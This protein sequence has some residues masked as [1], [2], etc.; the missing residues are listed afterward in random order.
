M[1]SLMVVG[2]AVGLIG[3]QGGGEKKVTLETQNDKV[4]YS[5]GV[6]IGNSLKRDSIVVEPEIVLRGMK[7]ASLDSA[8]RLLTEAQVQEI[9]VAFRQEMEKKKMEQARAAGDKNKV[10]GEAFLAANKTR[11]GVVTLPSGLQYEV[12]TEGKGVRPKP[13]QAVTT[14]YRGTLIDG[15]EFDSSYK[16]GEPAVFPVNRVIPGWTEALQLMKV[17][18]KWKLYVP[19]ALAYGERSPGGQIGP[20]QTLMFEIELLSIHG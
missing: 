14:H 2:I 7:D 15:T 10:E 20:N 6:N 8:K 16:R 12:I 17:G 1:K 4:S 19:A 11:P 9:I 18:S 5:I 13:D 3:C